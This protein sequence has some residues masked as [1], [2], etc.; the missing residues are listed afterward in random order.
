MRRLPVGHSC[1]RLHPEVD[2][3]LPSLM[4]QMKETSPTLASQC[5]LQSCLFSGCGGMTWALPVLCP[6]CLC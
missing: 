6:P 2:H 3:D 4:N 1:V 5:D